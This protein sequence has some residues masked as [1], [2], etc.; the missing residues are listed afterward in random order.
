MTLFYFVKSYVVEYI[1]AIVL[2]NVVF[3]FTLGNMSYYSID[4]HSDSREQKQLIHVTY[5]YYKLSR[6]TFICQIQ[7][8]ISQP[9]TG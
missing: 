4:L 9:M 6:A 8:I 7:F 2:I 5:G 3:F 1:V